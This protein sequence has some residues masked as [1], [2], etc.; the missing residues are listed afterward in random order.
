MV[1]ILDQH[2]KD[3]STLCLAHNVKQLY[4]FGS[5]LT[6]KFNT[7]SDVDLLVDFEP[8]E[9][10]EYADNYYDLKFSLESI[11]QKPVDL[12]EDKA[13]TNPYFRHVVNNQRQLI[14]GH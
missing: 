5:V 1:T 4:A 11:L 6:D 9:I 10:S 14:Y 13:I 8:I 12:L 2:I 7:D 3:I